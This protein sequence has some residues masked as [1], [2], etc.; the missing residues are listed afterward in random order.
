MGDNRVAN[1]N[2]GQ[3]VR[4]ALA[5]ARVSRQAIA[6]DCGVTPQAVQRWCD[7]TAMPSS[8]NLLALVRLTGASVEWLMWPHPVDLTSTDWAIK[9][10]HIKNIVRSVMDEIAAEERAEGE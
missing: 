7:G 3:R 5:S 10:R 8:A 4:V 1:R 9:G 2:F 6:R